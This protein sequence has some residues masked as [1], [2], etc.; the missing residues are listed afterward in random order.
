MKKESIAR[1][2]LSWWGWEVEGSRPAL[3]KYVIIVAPHRKGFADLLL[4]WLVKTTLRLPPQTF[5]AKYEVMR[6]PVVG[7]IL[8]SIGAVGIDRKRTFGTNVPKGAYVAQFVT[9]MNGS[10]SMVLVITPE[11]TRKPVPWLAGFYKI[12]RAA[13]VP[14]VPAGFDYAR[15]RVVIGTPIELTGKPKDDLAVIS[16]WYVAN[17]QGYR[18]VIDID[19]F[20]S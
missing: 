1:V 15:K 20:L 5:M 16:E 8:K 4:G 9:L 2:L 11:G 6:I 19:R 10:R 14:V 17:T 3:D 12:A 13:R 7:S 18:P